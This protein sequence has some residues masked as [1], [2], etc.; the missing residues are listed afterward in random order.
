MNGFPSKGLTLALLVLGGCAVALRSVTAQETIHIE[1]G[2]LCPVSVRLPDEP[3]RRLPL[4]VVL[5]GKGGTLAGTARMW[6]ELTDPKPVLVVPEA[7]YPLL[8]SDGKE[9]G[10]GRS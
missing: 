4:F 9:W 2:I 5:H 10:V 1:A 3:G 8:I 6:D 7:P